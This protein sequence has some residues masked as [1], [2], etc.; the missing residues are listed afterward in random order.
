MKNGIRVFVSLWY[1]L[2]WISHVYLGL[3]APAV[4]QAFG[5]TALFPFVSTLWQNLVLP[6]ITLCALLLAAFEIAV[7]LMLIYKHRWV[8]YGLVLSI[9]FNLCLILLGL[10]FPAADGLHDFLGNRLA[11]TIFIALQ[12]PLFWGTF[13]YSIPELIKH[14][15]AQ[16]HA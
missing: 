6:H 7:G 12:I 2:G 4:Y 10:G 16:K 9:F 13:E 15:L 5:A 14:R 11:N 8:K 1:L 3:F